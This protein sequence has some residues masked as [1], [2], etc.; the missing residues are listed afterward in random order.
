MVSTLKKES[1]LKNYF[2]N[3]LIFNEIDDQSNIDWKDFYNKSFNT[4][5][6]KK[7]LQILE[8]YSSILFAEH[9]YISDNVL[10][11]HS[12]LNKV[13]DLSKNAYIIADRTAYDFIEKHYCLTI[14]IKHICFIDEINSGKNLDSIIKKLKK[15]PY[16][17]LL[18]FGGGRTLDFAKFISLKSNIKL[19]S[20]PSSLATHVYASS[21]IHVLSPIKDLGF[22]KTIDG[23]SSHLSLIDITLL[24]KLFQKNRRLVLS[25]FGDLMAFI[26]SRHDWKESSDKGNERYSILVDKSIDFIIS[27]LESIDINK[28]LK[29]WI[30]DY[31]FI[32]CLLCN[33]TD[34][35]GSAPASGAEHLFARCIEDEVT[36]L[37]MHGEIVALGVLI[38]SYIRQKDVNKVK[39]L[40]KKF[41]ISNLLSNYNL[42]KIAIVNALEKS[43]YEGNKKNRF[44]IL[45]ELDTSFGLFDRIINEMINKK[46]LQ[47]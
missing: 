32:Q 30:G 41:E 8:C 34:W 31:I 23:D 19:L 26:N 2:E 11:V 17:H 6:N 35:V 1:K 15:D 37:P 3:F 36:E 27:K 9:D 7:T 10:I 16:L 39:K 18:A 28:P 20:I 21:K 33:V 25:G 13:K 47:E 45:N 24:D 4:A 42:N 38:F 44:T 5:R 14:N 29:E 12:L 46:L 40:M 22:N 43:L